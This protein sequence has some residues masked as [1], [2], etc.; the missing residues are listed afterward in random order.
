MI[1]IYLLSFF[2]T[3][4]SSVVVVISG[5]FSGVHHK[6]KQAQDIHRAPAA[7]FGGALIAVIVSCCT[8]F[9]IELSAQNE[10]TIRTIL[11]VAYG[12][13]LVGLVDDLFIEIRP[14]YRLFLVSLLS[15][16]TNSILGGV[17]V[18]GFQTIDTILAQSVLLDVFFAAFGAVCIVNAF[19]LIDGLNG[20]ASGTAIIVILGLA[21]LAGHVGHS[22]LVIF[23]GL[24]AASC[25][26]FWVINIITGKLL[27]GDCGAYF[28]G[29]ILAQMSFHVNKLGGGTVSLSVI[30]LFIYP[31]WETFFSIVRRLYFRRPAMAPDRRHL[32]HLLY[33]YLNNR[34]AEI[35][36]KA[37]FANS[38]ASLICL[39]L[40]LLS[41]CFSV[42][43]SG[44]NVHLILGFLIVICLYLIL[45][46]GLTY[47]CKK[48]YYFDE[49][50][51]AEG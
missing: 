24:L 8:I 23:L 29:F 44:K 7:R 36:K 12:V 1:V 49:N 9:F 11:C 4:F 5:L 34:F 13:L 20:L 41:M 28:L 18:V 42:F 15:L 45:Y 33:T 39:I 38:L 43:F 46:F 51:A 30:S 14:R 47:L 37:H 6:A 31:L 48:Q 27:L 26:G 40:P 3:M 16:W 35:T 32:H 19:N 21:L 17:G 10:N 22:D 2:A 50:R 25:F